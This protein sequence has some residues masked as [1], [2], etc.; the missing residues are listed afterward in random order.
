MTCRSVTM[1]SF[2]EFGLAPRLGNVV[3]DRTG[4]SGD[5]DFVLRY[6]DDSPPKSGAESSPV[7]MDAS[8]P[9]L[10][11]ALD[12]QLGLKLSPGK[13]PVETLVIDSAAKPSAN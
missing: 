11:I 7:E 13:A 8:L 9:S 1:K 6:V 10:P 3:I 12:E 2:A 5:F 4:L